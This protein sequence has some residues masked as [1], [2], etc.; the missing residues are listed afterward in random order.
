MA[1]LQT[2]DTA[3]NFTLPDENIKNHTLSEHQG[4]WVVLYFYP[5]ASTPGCTVQAC[6]MR[7]HLDDF[8]NQNIQ[9]FGISPD[10]PEKLKKFSEK[11]ELTFTLLGD[12]SKKTLEAYGVWQEKSMFGN[13]YMGATRTTYIINPEGEIAHVIPKVS[14]KTHTDQLLKWFT[15]NT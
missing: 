15:Q 13:K 12:E 8:K 9:I 4:Q 3:P 2:G 5:K 1:L 11:Q 6:S 7:D 10:S 14:P